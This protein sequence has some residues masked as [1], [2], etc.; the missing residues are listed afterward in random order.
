M[1]IIPPPSKKLKAVPGQQSL[2]AF[3]EK[4]T[5]LS[6]VYSCSCFVMSQEKTLPR[7]LPDWW[8]V[9]ALGKSNFSHI[10]LTS[11][12]NQKPYINMATLF[13]VLQPID[14]F[15]HTACADPEIFMRGGPTKMVIFGH[16]RGGVQPK[17]N[18]EITFF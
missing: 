17:K 5:V 12:K 11:V 18:P 9:L 8:Q 15:I 7:N 4:G 16:R 1:H 13:S 10:V 3:L 6:C 14:D 2:F